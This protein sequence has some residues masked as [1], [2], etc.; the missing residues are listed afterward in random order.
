MDFVSNTF[1]IIYQGPKALMATS[2]IPPLPLRVADEFHWAWDAETKV[3]TP[4][5][6]SLLVLPHPSSM[7]D[8]DECPQAVPGLYDLDWWPGPVTL[9]FRKRES[10]CFMPGRPV[11]QVMAVPR[12]IQRMEPMPLGEADDLADAEDRLNEERPALVTGQR[13][14]TDNAYGLLKELADLG[15]L[16]KWLHRGVDRE[17]GIVG[18]IRRHE[19]RRVSNQA[20]QGCASIPHR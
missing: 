5:N 14:C 16:P 7:S 3:S 9:F 19:D 17:F 8:G 10:S 20:A 6:H 11:A 18:R 13:G 12:S 15:R 2:D 1:E 4:K